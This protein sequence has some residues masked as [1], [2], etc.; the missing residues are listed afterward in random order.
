MT[1][2]FAGA[3]RMLGGSLTWSSGTWSKSTLGEPTESDDN[4][5][6][7]EEKIHEGRPLRTHPRHRLP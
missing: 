2:L 1:V 3:K 7:A 4:R 6:S 5:G